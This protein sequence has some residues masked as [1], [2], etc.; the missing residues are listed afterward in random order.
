[1]ILEAA[2]V[3]SLSILPVDG[4]EPVSFVEELQEEF[5]ELYLS[6]SRDCSIISVSGVS[7]QKVQVFRKETGYQLFKSIE[8]GSPLSKVSVEEDGDILVVPSLISPESYVYQY[9]QCTE[10]YSLT[11]TLDSGTYD[12]ATA[13]NSQY[14]LQGNFDGVIKISEY[15]YFY[16]ATCELGNA[17]TVRQKTS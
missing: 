5:I 3:F 6:V 13:I 4:S 15:S 2:G 9:H 17:S 7:M 8:V 12:E 1:M 11:K 14:I 10:S 16:N